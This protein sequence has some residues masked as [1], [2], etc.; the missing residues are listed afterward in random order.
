MNLDKRPRGQRLTELISRRINDMIVERRLKPG[1]ALP[2]ETDLVETFGVARS[3]VREAIVRLRALGV[4]EVRHG[5]GMFVARMPV[6]LLQARLRR[7]MEDQAAQAARHGREL[8][9]ILL[10]AAAA[11]A[12]SQKA[13]PDG[14]DRSLR[15]LDQVP[16]PGL[17]EALE[18]FYAC[19]GQACGNPLV[20]QLLA[21]LGLILRSGD[22]ERWKAEDRTL[23]VASLAG[24]VAAIRVGDPGTAAAAIGR[25]LGAAS[26]REAIPAAPP[27]P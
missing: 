3:V 8:R 13:D 16:G 10:E 24:V 11:S 17:G 27:T 9:A 25:H 12:A 23:L 1:D 19:L 26:D 15:S 20:E 22:Q 7:A 21:G 2:T 5:R 18:V 6:G 4:V 14:L